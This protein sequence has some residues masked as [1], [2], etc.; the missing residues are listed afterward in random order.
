MTL[1][2][3]PNY[4]GEFD[5]AGGMMSVDET[6]MCSFQILKPSGKIAWFLSFSKFKFKFQRKK[7]NIR[8]RA[9]RATRDQL[10]RL[11]RDKSEKP[12]KNAITQKP[13]LYTYNLAVWN[14]FLRE[15]KPLFIF[16][17]SIWHFDKCKV[18]QAL[19]PTFF[20]ENL[21]FMPC[22]GAIVCT[23]TPPPCYSP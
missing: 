5:N 12:K 20:C 4:C 1:F 16:K 17:F 14:P 21:K 10:L 22:F 11:E 7:P 23:V 6:L 8:T 3:A 19:L 15:L 2:S 18:L 9:W 13:N